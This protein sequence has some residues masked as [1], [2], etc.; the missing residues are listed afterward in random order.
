MY[1]NHEYTGT[2]VDIPTFIKN[3]TNKQQIGLFLDWQLYFTFFVFDSF[4]VVNKY[5]TYFN[6]KG[7]NNFFEIQLETFTLF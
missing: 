7:K 5:F 4:K 2:A 1:W 3:I 6:C